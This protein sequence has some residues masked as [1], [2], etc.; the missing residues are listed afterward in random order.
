[1]R[2]HCPRRPR[3]TGLVILALPSLLQAGEI[4]KSVDANGNVVYSD[5]AD[6]STAQTLVQ[7]EDSRYPPQEIHLCG[8]KNCFTLMRD[9]GS[10]HRTDGTDDTWIIE[11]FTAR[12]VVLRR[13]GVAT[14]GSDVTYAGEVANDRLIN[15][16]VDGKPTGGIATGG[17]DASWGSALNTL[18]GSNAERDATNLAIMDA[19][20]SGTVSTAQTPP[21]L[22]PEEQATLPEPGYLW[23]PGYWYWREQRYFWIP[24][25][26][27]QPPQ[28]GFLW[29]PAYW[30]P[31]G[32]LYTFHPGY[33]GRTVGF[34]GGINYGYGYFGNGFTGGR[35]V[36]NSFAYNSSVNHLS[37]AIKNTY[38]EP[39][40]NPGSR[41]VSSYRVAA[42]AS[43]MSTSAHRA[44]QPSSSHE[45]KTSNPVQHVQASAVAP[46]VAARPKANH[47]IPV[48]AAPKNRAASKT[49]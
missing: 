41:S 45:M 42:N 39:S 2:R 24:G 34:Y 14:G 28:A 26:W 29:T 11:T 13:H 19:G 3:I 20:S 22:P 49:M 21:P 15:V 8:S 44:A 48:K 7:L 38:A 10:Y 47:A 25:A 6:P 37:P 18:P 35:W 4:Y 43:A 33:W 31:V 40:A 1:M 9:H 17:I 27:V 36:G 32:T 46:S 5:H 12:S 23:T 30:G 16:T